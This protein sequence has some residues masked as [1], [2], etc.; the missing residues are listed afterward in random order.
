[1]RKYALIVN[2]FPC[3]IEQ[4]KLIFHNRAEFLAC[5]KELE[6]NFYLELKETGVRSIQ[7]NGYY[8]RIVE[9]LSDELGYT[10][11]EMHETLKNHFDI[12]STKH[13][14]QKEF[15]SYIERIIRWSAQ[16]MGIAIPDPTITAL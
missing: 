4:G 5:I 12:E 9:I 1:M 7:Q 10:K 3:K 16:E 13:L 15:S 6:G 14:E 11:Q 2:R 8:W